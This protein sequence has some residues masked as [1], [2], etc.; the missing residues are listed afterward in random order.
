MCPLVTCGDRE[1]RLRVRIGDLALG[2]RLV[3]EGALEVLEREREVED[4]DVALAERLGRRALGCGELGRNESS[5]N[6]SPADSRATGY[7]GLAQEAEAR[8]AGY[9]FR[10]FADRA[11][12]I[13]GVEIDESHRDC[14]FR[15]FPLQGAQRC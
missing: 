10:G 13:D 9:L 2:G 11:V 8:I 12:G 3:V 1:E 5:E 4:P 14:S 7:A 6:R 15:G